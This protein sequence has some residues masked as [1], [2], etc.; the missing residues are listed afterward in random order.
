MPMSTSQ[1]SSHQ[2]HDD[3]SK[4]FP[5]SNTNALTS[6][7]PQSPRPTSNL[8]IQ[9]PVRTRPV[10]PQLQ[11]PKSPNLNRPLPSPK[12]GSK[13]KK[14][15]NAA[16]SSYT[17]NEVERPPMELVRSHAF[18]KSEKQ[19]PIE[20]EE[21]NPSDSLPSVPLYNSA[22]NKEFDEGI[23]DR[24]LVCYSENLERDNFIF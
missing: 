4:T 12:K 6:S 9:S 24:K 22:P 21:E 5:Q 18:A 7:R 8:R 16:T 19:L 3:D 2:S 20:I 14:R 11:L 10:S 1:S 15:S 23:A 13:L 17:L